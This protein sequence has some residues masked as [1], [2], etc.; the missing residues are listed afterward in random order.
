MKI[1]LHSSKTMKKSTDNAFKLSVPVFMNEAKTI[2]Q[3]LRQVSKETIESRMKISSKLADGVIS[4]IND[5]TSLEEKQ[6]AAAVAFVGDIYSGLQ[7]NTMSEVEKNIAQNK[8]RIIS[9][10]YGILK[11]LDGVSSYRL[12]MAYKLSPEP[13]K[14]LYD[15]WGDKLAKEIDSDQ[16]IINLTSLE[17][18]KAIIPYLDKN[19]VISPLFLTKNPITNK[20]VNVAVHSK[21]T[22]GF[23]ASWLI[24]NNVENIEKLKTF[25]GL[26]YSYDKDLSSYNIPVFKT[27][28]FGGIGLSVR[29]KKNSIN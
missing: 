18:G 15:F 6:T 10:M 3:Y 23:M 25:D 2:N 28:S 14:N 19:K 4:Q 7:F 11:P 8:L 29:Q 1:L 21:I 20:Y 13:F 17:Y 12:E 22:R 9:G 26:G 16:E 24:R 5:W 27:D